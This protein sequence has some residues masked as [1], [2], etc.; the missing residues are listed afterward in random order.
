MKEIIPKDYIA[1][2]VQST[3][4]EV[5]LLLEI[6]EDTSGVNMSYNFITNR[7]GIDYKR[8]QEALNELPYTIPLELYIKVFTMHELGHAL[9][10]QALMDSL[11]KT[12]DIFEMKR[13]HSTHEIYNNVDLLA[14][15]IEEH[16]MN[17]AFEKTAWDNAALLNEEFK[18]VDWATF[19][20]LKAHSLSTYL[21]LY[22]EDLALYRAL[23]DRNHLV[24]A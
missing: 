21:Q 3:M 8:V 5:N 6:Q 14:M 1:Q 13:T 7:I 2:L 17:I 24:I 16:K 10:Q 15:I 9:D 4:I 11:Q 20:T 22:E 23:V 12:L 18:L 19:E